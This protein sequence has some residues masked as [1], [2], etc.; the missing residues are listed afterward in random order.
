[1]AG[2]AGPSGAGVVVCLHAGTLALVLSVAMPA[3]VHA[4]MRGLP[5]AADSPSLMSPSMIPP[6]PSLAPS[7]TVT[8]PVPLPPLAIT[9]A[10]PPAQP[11]A[12]SVAQVP[13]GQV[14]LVASARFG[15]DIPQPI[16]GGLLWRVYA[17]KP[18]A[19]GAFRPVREDRNPTPTFVLPPGQYVVHVS[20]GLAS[21][22][23]NVS[24][25]SETVREIFELPA[26]A[27]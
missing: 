19:T 20:F 4:Q 1:M 2:L 12:Q 3:K 21:A 18:D 10:Q 24:L 13:A 16:S 17:A 6:P 11:P 14:A 27:I 23:K 22:V 8:T 5:S 25:R 9:P 26:G 15:R 7:N